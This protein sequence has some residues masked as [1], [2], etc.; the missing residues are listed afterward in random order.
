[1]FEHLFEHVDTL[2]PAPDSRQPRRP[3]VNLAAHGRAT[4]H[5]RAR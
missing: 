5:R 1:L 3:W 2:N 4:P